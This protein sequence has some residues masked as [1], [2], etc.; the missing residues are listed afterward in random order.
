[1][2]PDIEDVEG[3]Y[4]ERLELG[5]Q[6]DETTLS[7]PDQ[8][9]NEIYGAFTDDEVRGVIRELK[10]N[11]AAG[12]DRVK[13]PDLR[14]ISTGHITAIMNYWWGWILPAE[15][16]ECRTT[17]LPKKEHNLEDVSNWLPITVGNLLSGY[18]QSCGTNTLGKM[19][20]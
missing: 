2:Y 11:T 9:D 17:L 15:S 6:T 19:L 12:V 8:I 5:N 13:T 20:H 1:M 7:F 4:E 14:R 18:T 3:V 10:K 16:E